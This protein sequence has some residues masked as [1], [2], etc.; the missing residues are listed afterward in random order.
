ML[1]NNR[2]TNKWKYLAV[3]PALLCCSILIAK[4]A[5]DT[6]RVKNGN[7]TVYKGNKF[8]WRDGRLDSVLVEDATSGER[9]WTYTKEAASIVRVNKDSVLLGNL[10]DFTNNG[11]GIKDYYTTEFRK[12]AGTLP[13][14]PDELEIK[15]LVISD[16]G[17]IIYY[18]A[19]WFS[20][21]AYKEVTDPYFTDLIN[22]ITEKSPDWSFGQR[23]RTMVYLQTGFRIPLKPGVR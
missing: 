14:S 5:S 21:G 16:A 10:D 6:R 17:R 8:Y 22:T 18:E 3:L 12:R 15:D 20:A 9:T 13:D 11:S 2:K 23:P 19:Y 4:P 1:T 7:V